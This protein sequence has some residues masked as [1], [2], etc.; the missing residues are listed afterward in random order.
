[1][2]QLDILPPALK[3]V[4]VGYFRTR[5]KERP[6]HQCRPVLRQYL[7]LE[8]FRKIRLIDYRLRSKFNA[9]A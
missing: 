5:A 6:I 4:R 3:R 9:L 1:M 8:R 7:N 2:Q